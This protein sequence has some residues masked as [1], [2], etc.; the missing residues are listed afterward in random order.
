M[1]LE[2]DL[3]HQDVSAIAAMIE[4]EVKSHIPDWEPREI[5][6]DS[7]DEEPPDLDSVYSK[8]KGNASPLANELISSF[9]NLQMERL[10]SG[11]KYWS[12]SP[13]VT[14]GKP[15]NSNLSSQVSPGNF[16]EGS[17]SDGTEDKE[18]SDTNLAMGEKC[19]TEMDFESEDMKKIA[20]QLEDLL[21]KQQQ[22]MEQLKKKHE[23][24]ISELL[25]EHSPEIRERV[26]ALCTLRIHS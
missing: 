15:G 17:N 19:E 20:G 5:L 21:V 2:L 8:L 10:P 25:K 22:E 26:R 11:H 23:L 4:S 9:S 12:D 1:V 18:A 7:V 3:S 14:R 6:V 16:E 24:A 13:K